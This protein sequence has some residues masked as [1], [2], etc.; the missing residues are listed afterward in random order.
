[1]SL[2]RLTLK[3]PRENIGDGTEATQDKFVKLE[4]IDKWNDKKYKVEKVGQ[5]FSVVMLGETHNNAE[6]QQKQIELIRIIRPEFVLH[7]FAFTWM[8]D[9]KTKI[10]KPQSGKL[11]D[12]G[13]DMSD[14]EFKRDL[15]RLT[16]EADALN[17]KIIGCDLSQEELIKFEQRL[18]QDYPKKYKYSPERGRV[19]KIRDPLYDFTAHSKELQPFREKRMM[20]TILECHQKSSKP[21]ICI[22]GDGHAR[23]IHRNKFLQ[24]KSIDYIYVYQHGTK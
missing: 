9:P 17:F 24:R 10:F 8:Y 23:A 4:V 20:D 18:A 14:K 6:T 19:I 1:M 3:T 2:E 16:I 15:A 22:M 21:I 5:R 11:H 12:Q 7:E 13:P